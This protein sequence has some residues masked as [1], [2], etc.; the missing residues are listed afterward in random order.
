[1]PTEITLFVAIKNLEAAEGFLSG[2]LPDSHV[3]P[4][5]ITTLTGAGMGVTVEVGI[6]STYLETDLTEE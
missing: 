5:G 6:Y 2:F 4:D 3:D 1:M